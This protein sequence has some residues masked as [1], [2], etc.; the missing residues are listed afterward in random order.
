MRRWTR[1]EGTSARP[2][3]V[4]AILLT[5]LL[6]GC[7]LSEVVIAEPEDLVVAEVLVQVRE[8]AG[9]ALPRVF[10]LLHRTADRDR[11]VPGA[12]I[13]LYREGEPVPLL[14]SPPM[15]CVASAPP[16]YAS[17]CYRA[18]VDDEIRFRPGDRLAL[19]ID[20]PGG[21]RLHGSG[22]IPG[23]FHATELPPGQ[24]LEPV[25]RI[26][27][28]TPLELRWTRSEGAWAYV[29]ET[30]IRNIQAAMA[31]R[32]IPMES[33]DLYLSGLSVSAADTTI[34]FPGEFGLLERFDADRDLLVA[35]QRGLPPGGRAR[36]S[37]AAVDRNY[38]NWARGGNFNPSGLVRVPSLAGDGTGFLGSAVLREWRLFVPPLPAGLEPPPCP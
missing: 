4:A 13:V 22:R 12:R 6:G 5:G 35:L 21:G 23:D 25:C 16:G 29:S 38:V 26:E 17:T 30:V 8:E 19:E 27:P 15:N 11:G 9:E 20:L 18:S 32:G 14:E 10:A 28:D 2:A 3:R 36:V 24:G 37:V 33:D 34:V 7:E 31:E 1:S